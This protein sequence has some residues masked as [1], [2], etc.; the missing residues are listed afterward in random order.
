MNPAIFCLGGEASAHD[1]PAAPQFRQFTV[2]KFEERHTKTDVVVPVV[3]VVPVAVGAADVPLIVV[4]GT[5]A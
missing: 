4:E 3:R 2:K 5:A 1:R